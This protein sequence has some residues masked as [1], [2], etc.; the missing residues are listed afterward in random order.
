MT[1][2]ILVVIA[3]LTFDSN[4]GEGIKTL[5]WMSFVTANHAIVMFAYEITY[6]NMV[7][8]TRLTKVE[9]KRK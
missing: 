7:F 2:T 3:I 4:I 6:K 8:T 5:Q 9:F 1:V